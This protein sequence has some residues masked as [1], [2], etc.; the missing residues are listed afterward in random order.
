[1]AFRLSFCN[2]NIVDMIGEAAN[3]LAMQ[4]AARCEC[5]SL[6]YIIFK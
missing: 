1:M 5:I 4:T 3:E 2:S 6:Q